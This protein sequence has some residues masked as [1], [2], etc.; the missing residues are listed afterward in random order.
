[1]P[2]HVTIKVNDDLI[3]DVHIGRIEGGANPKDINKYVVVAGEEP[4]HIDTWLELGKQFDHRYG[5]GALVCV[6]KALE[7]LEEN[8]KT[9]YCK[10]S[11]SVCGVCPMKHFCI[12]AGQR[13][14]SN[15]LL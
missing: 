4:L 13:V 15:E 2:L 11:E 1:M 14:S 12:K 8:K 5:D 3:T 9:N 7:A 6:A 10:I